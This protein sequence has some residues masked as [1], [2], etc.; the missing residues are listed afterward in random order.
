MPQTLIG[1]PPSFVLDAEARLT[2]ERLVE[3]DDPVDNPFSEEQQF[4]L[5]DTIKSSYV[6]PTDPSRPGQ[7]RKF[8][9][10]ANVGLF[11]TP[12]SFL[13]PDMFISLDTDRPDDCMLDRAYY[14]F[15][16]KPP[17]VV[18]E[19]V[20]NKEG[21]EL[22]SKKDT[23]A[24][25]GIQYYVVYDPW[26]QL[27]DHVLQVFTLDGGRYVPLDVPFLPKLGI[28][29]TLWTGVYVNG[30]ERTYVRWCDEG[31]VPLRTGNEREA[32]QVLRT[33]EEKARADEAEK[34]AA[35]L[36][37]MLLKHGIDPGSI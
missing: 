14:L 6:P 32:D 27:G 20:S 8:W 28:G 21:N 26:C 9:G 2:I 18:V 3:A 36:R 1:P 12:T 16:R 34:R 35:A 29:V 31:G 30:K 33:E 22:Y 23:Y 37:A 24:Q 5:F 10:A 13:V 17:E 7:R 4:L 25:W 11:K 15:E 19:V